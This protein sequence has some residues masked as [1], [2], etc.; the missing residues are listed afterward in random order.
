LRGF[1][2]PRRGDAE[3]M[4]ETIQLNLSK[5]ESIVL[6]EFL[7]RFSAEGKLEIADQ[8]EERILWNLCCDL[9]RILV[10]PFSA[11]YVKMLENA[12][13]RIRDQV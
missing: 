6:F 8:S 2:P 4:E 5:D 10:E 9:E 13:N 3:K 7:S 1:E 12:R 11:E